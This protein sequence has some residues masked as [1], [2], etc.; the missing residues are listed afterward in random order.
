MTESS[1]NR[2]RA[3]FSLIPE[4]NYHLIKYSRDWH[5]MTFSSSVSLRPVRTGISE[6]DE[7]LDAIN[8]FLEGIQGIEL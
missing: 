6:P 7:L 8:P 1:R 5:S 3:L 2:S 4:P